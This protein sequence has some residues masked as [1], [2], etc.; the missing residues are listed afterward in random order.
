MRDVPSLLELVTFCMHSR[1]QKRKVGVPR[2]DACRM[3]EESL[4]VKPVNER[5]GERTQEVTVRK[6]VELMKG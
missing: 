5:T 3:E 2:G 1:R 6:T 4:A